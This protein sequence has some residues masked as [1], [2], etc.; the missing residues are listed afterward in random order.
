MLLSSVHDSVLRALARLLRGKDA[1]MG[2]EEVLEGV[3]EAGQFHDQ[4]WG[5]HVHRKDL[6]GGYSEG[7]AVSS[8]RPYRWRCM[9]YKCV[10]NES[11]RG[12]QL[13]HKQRS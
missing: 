2:P 1:K 8:Q 3:D 12:H 13:C 4:R 5:G 7:R 11:F 9:R 10:T 6:R